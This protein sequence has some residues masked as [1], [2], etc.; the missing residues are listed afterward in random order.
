MTLS[1]SEEWPHYFSNMIHT[2]SQKKNVGI[3][4]LWSKKEIYINSIPKEYY[5]SIGQLY[6]REE[7]V[8]ALI[9]N[10]CLNT[11]ITDLVIVG[12]DLNHCADAVI[13][14]FEKGVNEENEIICEHYS[15]V[16]DEI[17]KEAIERIRTNVKLHDFREFKDKEVLAEKIKELSQEHENGYHEIEMFK[18]AEIKLPDTFPSLKTGFTTHSKLVRDAW[19]E[20]LKKIMSFGTLKMS[21][22]GDQQRELICMVSTITGEDPQNF[23]LMDEF[24][25]TKEEL[26]TYIPQVTTVQEIEGLDYTYGQKLKAHRGIDQIQNI[27]DQINDEAYTRRAIG[28]TWDVAVDYNN[29]KCPCLNSVQV[30]VQDDILY[31]TCYFRSNDMFEAWPRNTFALRS[32]QQEICE[33]TNMQLGHLT[34]VSN[35]AHVYERSFK[36][37]EE[38]LEKKQKKVTWDQDAHGTVAIQVGEENIMVQHMDTNGK[39]LE[40]F[41]GKTA[42]EL[43]KIIAGRYKISDI[44]HAMDIGCELQ[45]AEIALNQGIEFLQDKPLN[46]GN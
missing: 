44:S 16:D 19:I 5:N 15:K 21:Q 29:P 6:S 18:E 38:I 40:Q 36:K 28:F 39:R 9:R 32:L 35:S 7:G 13:D 45:K 8:S 4:T 12:A 11:Y 23:Q 34:I 20:I 14:F 43:Y 46:F 1:I 27:I 37:I 41:E 33:K 42:M 26:E 17:S 24:G 3:I 31:M 25:F 10:L 2:E 30:L 22:Y